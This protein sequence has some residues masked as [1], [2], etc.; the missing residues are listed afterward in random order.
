VGSVGAATGNESRGGA[1]NG[2]EGVA[3]SEDNSNVE[4]GLPVRIALS[5]RETK[6]LPDPAPRALP[7][8]HQAVPWPELAPSAAYRV[9]AFP[10]AMSTDANRSHDVE[11]ETQTSW[12]DGQMPLTSLAVPLWK[13]AKE[14]STLIPDSWRPYLTSPYL[15]WGIVLTLILYPLW[16]LVTREIAYRRLEREYFSTAEAKKQT[17]ATG[18]A[19][20][21][22]IDRVSRTL[23]VAWLPSG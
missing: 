18:A 9:T 15:L 10:R 2:L 1:G 20:A 3:L 17:A 8:V 5:A 7:E 22:D 4:H 12:F 13:A 19:V 6:P 23:R 14:V 21:K 16:R 11:T